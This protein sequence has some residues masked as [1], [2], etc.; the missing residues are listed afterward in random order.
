EV[1]IRA[2]DG[3]KID[4]KQGDQ[5]SV[6]QTNDAMVKAD[7]HLAWLK[8]AEQRGDGQWRQNKEVHDSF[9][10]HKS[11]RGEGAMLAIMSVV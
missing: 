10:Y 2:V 6:S 11:S 4:I 8:D 9:K 3:L 7:P 1:A 5:Q